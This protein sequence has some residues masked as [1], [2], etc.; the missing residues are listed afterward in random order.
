MRTLPR[1]FPS[2]IG[3]GG[4]IQRLHNKEIDY[5][6]FVNEYRKMEAMNTDWFGLLFRNTVNHNHNVSVS[7]GTKTVVNRTSFSLQE[8]LGEAKGNSLSNFSAASNT[9]FHFGDRV[10]VNFLLSGSMNE[11][12]GFAYEVDPFNYALNTA[13]TIP[14]YHDDGTFFY[15][16]KYGS[17]STA[18]AGKNTYL[19]NIQNELD[20]T[21]QSNKTQTL[22][23]TVDLAVRL[24]PRLKFESM[25]NYSFT[26]SKQKMYATE[27]S[28][29][30]TQIRGYEFGEVAANSPAEKASLLP[31]GGLV[32]LEDAMSNDYTFRNSLIYNE[33]FNLKHRLSLQL[34]VE[35]RSARMEGQTNKRYGYL[36]YRGESYAPLPEN[37]TTDIS[38]FNINR[39][40]HE[41][42]RTG[43]RIVNRKNNYLSEYFTAV[44]N[45]DSRYVVNLNARMDASNRFGQDKNKRFEPSWSAGGKWRLGNERWFD[46]ARWLDLIDL[47]YAYGYTGNSVESV[48]PYLIARDGGLSDEYKQYILTIQSLPYPDLGWEKTKSWNAALDFSLLGGWLSATASMFRK[49]S[50]VLSGKDVPVENGMASAVVFGTK[51]INKGYEFTVN[52]IPV[53]T[54]DFTWQLQLNSGLSRNRIQYNDKVN[55]YLILTPSIFSV[56]TVRSLGPRMFAGGVNSFYANYYYRAGNFH[57]T[58]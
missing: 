57:S 17:L 15:H 7:G 12:Q 53:R 18:V 39:S 44:C 36:R 42:M 58:G 51:M 5:D 32:Q 33:T 45:Y 19:Y 54:Q 50:D 55:T 24:T 6:T 46:Q 11:T 31:F 52:L 3:F 10:T 41:E 47:S 23:G 20:N 9:T 43:S 38:G 34:G 1:C 28:H 27:F 48:S 8:Q 29:Y 2:G 14:M 35:V 30:I 26:S 40:L 4:L 13:R 16:E 56:G 49:E 37:V 21:G 25:F 22:K